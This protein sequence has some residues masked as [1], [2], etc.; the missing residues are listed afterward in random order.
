MTKNTLRDRVE[1]LKAY[2]A[3]STLKF[4]PIASLRIAK[5]IQMLEKEVD[6]LTEIRKSLSKIEKLSEYESSRVAIC[7]EYS[8]KKED[9][10]PIIINGDYAFP[11][12]EIYSV[13]TQKIAELNEM[14]S[15]TVKEKEAFELE[16]A[17]LLN[18]VVEVSLQEVP[19]SSCKSEVSAD[20]LE[21]ILDFLSE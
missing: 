7:E 19:M 10:S 5:N 13:C 2:K 6:L 18:S 8:A 3:L 20:I 14:Y 17:A 9:G 21:P 12:A 15:S 16:Y 1:Q 4:G 11:S